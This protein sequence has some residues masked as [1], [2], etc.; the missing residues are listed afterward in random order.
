MIKGLNESLWLHNTIHST[1]LLLPSF[2]L[3]FEL[4]LGDVHVSAEVAVD[5]INDS[6]CWFSE[7]HWDI[8]LKSLFKQ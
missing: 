2:E 8:E 3:G 1:P 7:P 6:V 4:A 5:I